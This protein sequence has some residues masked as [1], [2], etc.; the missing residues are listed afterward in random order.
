MERSLII[1]N[2]ETSSVVQDIKLKVDSFKQKLE[3]RDLRF[4]CFQTIAGNMCMSN[5]VN[6]CTAL[7]SLLNHKLVCATKQGA[8]LG[9]SLACQVSL[10]YRVP[11]ET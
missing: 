5:Y 7:N 6:S 4:Q 11:I 1:E 3:V 9:S 2:G 8:G 10:A